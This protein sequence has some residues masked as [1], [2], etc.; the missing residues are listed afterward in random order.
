V[1]AL[2]MNRPGLVNIRLALFAIG[3]HPPSDYD[4]DDLPS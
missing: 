2:N 4:Q 3:S 1:I